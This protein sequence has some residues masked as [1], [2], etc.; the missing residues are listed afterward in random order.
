MCKLS[1]AFMGGQVS[2]K[3]SASLRSCLFCGTDLALMACFSCFNIY[4]IR[5]LTTLFALSQVFA[6]EKRSARLESR[7]YDAASVTS[8]GCF[9]GGKSLNIIYSVYPE[10]EMWKE[11]TPGVKPLS[12][13]SLPR[14]CLLFYWPF[15]SICRE[16]LE[17]LAMHAGTLYNSAI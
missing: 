2:V 1:C 12:P 17:N 11:K 8:K 16:C 10:K 13:S 3:E 14:F 6:L 4:D 15:P 7:W 5:W 9:L